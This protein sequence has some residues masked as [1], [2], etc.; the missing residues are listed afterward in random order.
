MKLP[1]KIVGLNVLL[2]AL[3]IGCG[4]TGDRT[5]LFQ[6]LPS[7][8]TGLRFRNDL[9]FSQEFNIFTYRNFYNGGGVGIGDIN[10]DGLPDV[11]FTSNLGEN[12]LYLNKGSFV[13]EDITLPSGVKGSRGWSTGVAM[14]DVNGD[15]WLDIYV[16]NSGDVDGDNRQ[17]ELFINQGDLTFSEEAERYGLADSGLSTHAAFFDYDKDGDLDMYLLNNSFTAI[18]T[19]NLMN[20][21]RDTRDPRGGD[22]LFRNDGGRFQDVSEEAGIYGSEIGFGLGVTVGDVN[23]DTWPDIFISNDFFERD[24]LY[25]NQ[26]NGTF[27]EELTIRLQS[28]S[29]A[30]MGSDMADVNNDGWLDVFVTDMLP[31]GLRRMKQITTFENWDKFNYNQRNGYHY[32]LTRNML[33]LNRG[34]GV[35][36]EIGRL[37]DVE[38]TDWSWGALMFDMDNDGLKD[39]FVANG[40]YQDITDLDYLNFIDSDETKRRI[41]SKEGVDYRALIDPIPVN[42]VPNYAFKNTGDLR[43]DNRADDWGLG[44]PSHSNGSAYGD[45]DSDGDLDLVVS[46]LNNEVAVYENTAQ[47]SQTPPG[48]LRIK[49]Q[50][51][52]RN[53][54]GVGARVV[55]STGDRKVT[56]EQMPTRGFQS[57]VDP[58]MVIGLGKAAIADTLSVS[59]PSG[60]VSV[61]VNVPC[62]QTLVIRE[63]DAREPGP[64]RQEGA[65]IFAKVEGRLDY[66]HTEN[67]FVDFDRERL[68]YQMLSTSGPPAAVGDLNGDGLEDVWL[69]GSAGSPGTI[70][71]QNPT[72]TFTRTE[73]P[74]LALDRDSEDTDIVLGDLDGDGDLD[75]VVASGGSEFGLGAPA[76]RD[77]AYLN[78]GKGDFTRLLGTDLDRVN[79]ITS[80]LVLADWDNDG[81]LDLF[82]GSRMVPFAYG[83]TPGSHLFLNDGSGRLLERTAD[84]AS[85]LSG[86]GMITDA[87][88]LDYDGD[89][90][91]DLVLVGDWTGILILENHD[92]VFSLSENE[93]SGYR[94]WWNT[95]YCS[96]IDQDG[97]PDLVV[98]N[99][100]LNSRFK[101]NEEQKLGL[102]VGDFDSNGSVEPVYALNQKDNWTPLALRHDLIAQMPG[103]KKKFLKYADYNNLAL[104]D[105]FGKE[106]LA[107]SVRLEANYMATSVV[108]NKGNGRWQLRPLPVEAQFAPV[109]AISSLDYNKDGV[110]DLILAGNLFEVKPE[111]GRYDALLGGVLLQGK[112]NM[113]FEA[114]PYLQTGLTKVLSA[115]AI[116]TID[117]ARQKFL[118]VT[119]NQ[120]SLTLYSQPE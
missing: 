55:V 53:T 36:S 28:I 46:Q 69:G 114:V 90:D 115:R 83:M 13:F 107:K 31:G 33:H 103:L 75:A 16:C 22:K 74:A 76:L 116:R 49:L 71:F 84:R 45:L 117:V 12:K 86:L 41:I 104:H 23:N 68:V 112:G 98:G 59:W 65:T 110:S 10:N 93:L 29:A 27:R 64:G 73:Q 109:Y 3:L 57:S 78:N 37:A 66:Q 48:Y 85:L 47:Q 7:S 63:A 11:Y 17:N 89:R 113:Q 14:A 6:Q 39:I 60:K 97:D 79:E 87:A 101:F 88:A 8:R 51:G 18:G 95:V 44:T 56:L 30:S 34:G 70:F 77:R 42:P 43:F 92:G 106:A 52:L 58:V 99:H 20:N 82:T 5:S 15:G 119:A 118:M 120:D 62:K 26:K 1:R 2:A 32:Q 40:I 38:A 96:D 91:Q 54:A 61:L 81:D 4:D 67:T 25:I 24:Y 21:L 100:G 9:S 72:G 105:V 94:G 108:E 102:F 19:F 111:A 35:F 50:G 80:S